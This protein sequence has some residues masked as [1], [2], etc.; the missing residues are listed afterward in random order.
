MAQYT[1]LEESEDEAGINFLSLD[2]WLEI[3]TVANQ[4]KNVLGWD[5]RMA[6]EVGDNAGSCRY[7]RP[8]TTESELKWSV[9]SL[10]RLIAYTYS[11]VVYLSEPVSFSPP[12]KA[13]AG[14]A[15]EDEVPRYNSAYYGSDDDAARQFFLD[16]GIS[17]SG[18]RRVEGD[19]WP[20]D[21]TSLTDPAYTFGNAHPGD[22][23]GPWIYHDIQ[24]C[25]SNMTRIIDVAGWRAGTPTVNY[26]SGSSDSNVYAHQSFS[27]AATEA[28]SDFSSGDNSGYVEEAIPSASSSSVVRYSSYKY[29]FT[30][31][32][33]ARSNTLRHFTWEIPNSISRDIEYFTSVY[34]Y[35]TDGGIQSPW[36]SIGS[37]TITT[38][39]YGDKFY[40][41][42]YGNLNLPPRCEE[43]PSVV[44]DDRRATSLGWVASKVNNDG[45]VVSDFEWDYMSV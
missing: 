33:V 25:F 10:Q 6:S 19:E 21:W 37:D 44:E 3:T 1:N 43:P 36:F 23:I 32:C 4:I 18:L 29:Y 8:F 27:D 15:A 12:S 45:L 42:V 7:D 2:L 30:Y 40:S 41:S 22:I 24:K 11:G 38:T 17:E 5:S 16:S 20:K 9:R 26:N 34:S 14:L 28:E 35:D 39:A 13:I 31:S